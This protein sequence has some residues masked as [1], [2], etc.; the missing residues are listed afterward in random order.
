MAEMRNYNKQD[1]DA[2]SVIGRTI[3][4]TTVLAA[5]SGLIIAANSPMINQALNDYMFRKGHRR[6]WWELPIHDPS[7][8][9][10]IAETGFLADT[11]E[12]VARIE[13]RLKVMRDADSAYAESLVTKRATLYTDVSTSVAN[14]G[15]TPYGSRIRAVNNAR[16]YNTLLR[17]KKQISELKLKRLVVDHTDT[18]YGSAKY[19][20][21]LKILTSMDP[22]ND[23][24][25]QTTRVLNDAAE[26]LHGKMVGADIN[27][28]TEKVNEMN[29]RMLE[30]Q[31][32]A[33][34]ITLFK[35][36]FTDIASDMASISL[37][38]DTDAAYAMTPSTGKPTFGKVLAA[39]P[40]KDPHIQGL[41]AE[42][43]RIPTLRTA[44]F[45]DVMNLKSVIW[46]RID[47]SMRNDRRIAEFKR[48]IKAADKKAMRAELHRI[49]DTAGTMVPLTHTITNSLA[50]LDS[51]YKAIQQLYAELAGI[52]QGMSSNFKYPAEIRRQVED[53]ARYIS[54]TGANINDQHM[55]TRVSATE[56]FIKVARSLQDENTL[57]NILNK[58]DITDINGNA[59]I[60]I[61]LKDLINIENERRMLT[62]AE[63]AA[64]DTIPAGPRKKIER[65][66]QAN[67]DI[68]DKKIAENFEHIKRKNAEYR[69][70]LKVARQMF[71]EGNSIEMPIVDNHA[72]TRREQIITEA[73][74]RLK[75]RMAPTVKAHMAKYMLPDDGYE[76]PIL[77]KELNIE[78]QNFDALPKD[79]KVRRQAIQG[80]GGMNKAINR[81]VTALENS[82]VSRH[83]IEEDLVGTDIVI[84]AKSR[85]GRKFEFKIPIHMAN[86]V[87][88]GDNIYGLP[89]RDRI[90]DNAGHIEINPQLNSYLE[91]QEN[92]IRDGMST[93]F[94]GNGTRLPKTEIEE[95]E[96]FERK[97]Q[98][99]D[100]H[101]N[102][103]FGR[104]VTKYRLSDANSIYQMSNWLLK[105][106]TPTLQRGY[107]SQ[108]MQRIERNILSIERQIL[109]NKT[110]SSWS[111]AQSLEYIRERNRLNQRLRD[112]KAQ[113]N[114]ALEANFDTDLVQTRFN[115]DI[116]RVYNRETGYE[117]A[118]SEINTASHGSIVYM[119]W[120]SRAEVAI[121]GFVSWMQT[122]APHA[123][124][125]K[126]I[127]G[128]YNVL[129]S[130]AAFQDGES[131]L[132]KQYTEYYAS[133]ESTRIPSPEARYRLMAPSEASIL[134][135][136]NKG[137]TA[138]AYARVMRVHMPTDTVIVNRSF[139][140]KMKGVR[141]HTAQL[142]PAKNS[143]AKDVLKRTTGYLVA[144]G[145]I[146]GTDADISGSMDK[147]V[148]LD[149]KQLLVSED[150]RTLLN[151]LSQQ[152][153]ASP[154]KLKDKYRPIYNKTKGMP[155]E[156]Q[157]FQIDSLEVSSSGVKIN[158]KIMDEV[159][160][161]TK[162]IGPDGLKAMVYSFDAEDFY[163]L[164]ASYMKGPDASKETLE[165]TKNQLKKLNLDIIASSD[166]N[167]PAYGYAVINTIVDDFMGAVRKKIS[168]N[169]PNMSPSEQE[170]VFDKI[171]KEMTFNLLDVRQKLGQSGKDLNSSF[172]LR[173]E[174][175]SVWKTLVAG[176]T[177]LEFNRILS[178]KNGTQSFIADILDDTGTVPATKINTM[179][180]A[181][182]DSLEKLGLKSRKDKYDFIEKELTSAFPMIDGKRGFIETT[183]VS[184]ANQ[185]V[186]D[187]HRIA[188]NKQNPLNG[189][190]SG[191]KYDPWS[192]M[193]LRMKGLNTEA[194]GLLEQMKAARQPVQSYIATVLGMQGKSIE[195]GFI[196][197]KIAD[198]LGL[199]KS[200]LTYQVMWDIKKQ[201]DKGTATF[202]DE[203]KA[204]TTGLRSTDMEAER[205]IT[206]AIHGSHDELI[207]GKTA[208]N[209]DELNEIRAARGT[210]SQ[211]NLKVES[212]AFKGN[213]IETLHSI[214]ELSARVTND[215]LV[216]LNKM[217]KKYAGIELPVSV[218][219]PG[220]VNAITKVRSQGFLDDTLNEGLDLVKV[221]GMV[222]DTTGT[223]K[224]ETNLL[225]AVHDSF[226]KLQ[227]KSYAYNLALL[228]DSTATTE[229][230]AVA[231]DNIRKQ[232]EDFYYK[233]VHAVQTVARNSM[234]QGMNMSAQM[235]GRSEFHIKPELTDI[236]TLNKYF[237]DISGN[238]ALR[239]M[240]PKM[241]VVGMDKA[242]FVQMIRSSTD[243]TMRENAGKLADR[244][245]N[246]SLT[247]YGILSR[248]PSLFHNAYDVFKV[249]LFD[250]DRMHKDGGVHDD[251][252][253]MLRSSLF[254]NR[255]E[256]LGKLG[257]FDLD[258]FNFKLFERSR[259]IESA[260]EAISSTAI[261]KAFHISKK[262]SGDGYDLDLKGSGSWARK[263]SSLLTEHILPARDLDAAM[264]IAKTRSNSPLS[265]A[266]KE[267]K[268]MLMT[269][270]EHLEQSFKDTLDIKSLDEAGIKDS[271]ILNL[272]DTDNRYKTVS[273]LTNMLGQEK[274]K[275]AQML[276]KL[277]DAQLAGK[278]AAD[279][280]TLLSGRF[281]LVNEHA[282]A[283]KVVEY[284][285]RGYDTN[286]LARQLD[287]WTTSTLTSTQADM[288][289]GM[290]EMLTSITGDSRLADDIV[291]S[292]VKDAAMTPGEL[293]NIAK[294]RDSKLV[295]SFI[296]VKLG[297]GNIYNFA[298]GILQQ[299]A[300][301][302]YG[303]TGEGA[304][305]AKEIGNWAWAPQQINISSKHMMP[306]IATSFMQTVLYATNGANKNQFGNILEAL[307]TGNTYLEDFTAG[308]TVIDQNSR[309]ISAID[310]ITGALSKTEKQLKDS[311]TGY[312]KKVS[313]ASSKLGSKMTDKNSLSMFTMD[314]YL[315]QLS[316]KKQAM[317]FL[318]HQNPKHDTLANID[319]SKELT[320]ID[321]SVEA[322]N[323]AKKMFQ[324]ADMAV[325]ED[326]LTRMREQE[327]GLS[328]SMKSIMVKLLSNRNMDIFS[329]SATL[330]S[331]SRLLEGKDHSMLGRLFNSIAGLHD[332]RFDIKRETA[333]LS[334]DF[335]DRL[336]NNT[337]ASAEK[338]E[339]KFIQYL[340]KDMDTDLL[341]AKGGG[342]LGLAA[343][344][345][346][347]VGAIAASPSSREW[348]GKS[349]GM[350]GE[351]YDT[352]FTRD[353]RQMADKENS[354]AIMDSNMSRQ[355]YAG[356]RQKARVQVPRL[357]G[358]HGKFSDF[359]S[360]FSSFQP[361]Y[362]RRIMELQSNKGANIAYWG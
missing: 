130:W 141:V 283:K 138:D 14:K 197:P 26:S 69:K 281:M 279:I 48:F 84:R 78:Y 247:M 260:T 158:Y 173:D 206:E 109:E 338:S 184:M 335:M 312:R 179:V 254:I 108:Q 296:N 213:I 110:K 298:H 331:Y 227:M 71:D 316:I 274:R 299:S 346:G 145:K 59:D 216:A 245:M 315:E 265:A 284:S 90:I 155:Q 98:K 55:G 106:Y 87:A 159:T 280:D 68:L 19:R 125:Q 83:L 149:A 211:I 31:K 11:P 246:G 256:A 327:G 187:L 153:N 261:E 94:H 190:I 96:L 82:G 224:Q 100:S 235:I 194:E 43:S 135:N 354:Q 47:K 201:H 52:L 72:I 181:M 139:A 167:K 107:E 163:D 92:F 332:R 226:R 40:V 350:G 323:K 288:S 259:Y 91:A 9:V 34:E 272:M 169:H 342:F 157:M 268:T 307:K 191:V 223:T 196:D 203:I 61:K 103:A 104:H 266:L 88:I 162:L 221:A 219:L 347:F 44:E 23:I 232:V 333:S 229:D 119:P 276:Y 58:M 33:D 41:W 105:T 101:Y 39:S 80:T 255:M 311:I 175:N 126:G 339:N 358:A 285:N 289:K 102:S 18:Q 76:A 164:T 271:L 241:G 306:S 161:A 269:V 282:N 352:T 97:Q 35:G 309:M 57:G 21:L 202:G 37:E 314:D 308:R 3:A 334:T 154:T 50:T 357:P 132:I 177:D 230:L 319:L 220:A 218:R 286:K 264:E 75:A 166:V 275:V 38:V 215:Q 340:M 212:V 121:R 93:M 123:K 27:A 234:K 112:L 65:P 53:L 217:M 30:L 124:K 343:V 207:G 12:Q 362:D 86:I 120:G 238:T 15:I 95:N 231:R 210:L 304:W 16:Q 348:L 129:P 200:Y 51:T 156:Q 134:Q 115:A 355:G 168:E 146:K 183:K 74:K 113:R 56:E 122:N 116:D 225:S 148:K 73:G 182:S 193:Y 165:A 208:Q 292:F 198:R 244:L 222:Q 143:F 359:F 2:S 66:V 293:A 318:A 325:V 258:I 290:H 63:Q 79:I 356:Y 303:L 336:M 257:D 147:T 36:K 133:R 204:L 13:N 46:Q 142:D 22:Y 54:Y 10:H 278:T 317:S 188:T 137:L 360:Q 151:E 330:Q 20:K 214:D 349:P 313:E 324:S 70:Q 5:T 277:T 300:A 170:K 228:D 273:S 192:L 195:K 77:A 301:D 160:D 42:L 118:M 302:L 136:S 205:L 209:M 114:S 1:T 250:A 236:S 237:H 329:S 140:S 25:T 320:D 49:R 263:H 144:I 7:S 351:Y 353:E 64:N 28:I 4:L 128:F 344:I 248:Q 310:N 111:G 267:N 253:T 85:T 8:P 29:G 361:S 233:S 171:Y 321:E 252:M 305:K 322:I 150:G 172:I 294:N 297:T 295:E 32:N 60:A 240:T 186:Y 117:A 239:T 127:H 81:I 262:A 152:I 131:P 345:G 251:Q 62:T 287:Q 249:G 180:D 67:I 270:K 89:G 189:F 199:K 243:A 178:S 185:P 174:M 242:A 337:I 328:G 17:R 176:D 99:I 326:F 291:R 341:R 45:D 24:I 6:K